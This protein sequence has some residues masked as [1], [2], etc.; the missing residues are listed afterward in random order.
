MNKHL[1]RADL[2]LLTAWLALLM[3][4]MVHR[5]LALPYTSD[6][7][8][9]GQLIAQIRAGLAPGRDLVT[10]PFH[11]QTLVLM[12]LLFWFGTMPGGMDLT[13]VRIGVVVAHITGALGCAILCTR[14]TGSKLAGRVAGMLYAGALGF[15]GEQIWWPSSGIF[16]LGVT[17]FIL[18]LVALDHDALWLSILMLILAALGLNGVVVGAL[19]LPIYYWL[20]RRRRPPIALLTAIVL[21][22]GL[23]LWQQSGQPP[24]ISLRGLG[25]GAWLVFTAPFRFLNAWT[26]FGPPGFRTLWQVAPIVWLP[27]LASVWRMNANYRRVL[28]AVWTPAILLALLIGFTRADYPDRFGPGS[29]YTTDRYYYFFLFPLVA[30]CALLLSTI[31]M[32]PLAGALLFVLIAAALVASRSRY[33]ANVPRDNFQA[34]GHALQQGRLLVETIRSRAAAQPLTLTDAPIPIDGARGNAL[35]LAFLIYSEY[36]Q[37]IPGVRLVR[38]SINAE[39]ASIENLLLNRWAASAGLPAS[40]ACV[41]DGRL[42]PIRASSRIDFQNASYEEALVSGFSWWEAPFRWMRARASLRL[43]A[44]PGDLVISAY[45]PVDQ[46]RRAIHMT[47]TIDGRPVGVFAITAPGVHDYRLQ[48]PAMTYGAPANIT[49]SS[50]LIW[51]ARDILPQS[52]DER[53]LSIAVSAIGLSDPHQPSEPAPCRENP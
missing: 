48:P 32:R 29:F 8:E 19:G 30:H 43:I 18:A 9:H 50:D 52:F 20:L 49:L 1:S 53:D 39:Q 44:A 31:Q 2:C 26:T 46:L 17:F 33:L 27:L 6:D 13:W 3:F 42:Q 41:E 14:W 35:T 10:I 16:C 15:I 45:A 24:Q 28:I 22:L 21:L 12:R 40:P 4:W 11:G 38:E 7:F 5:T 51:H 23:G 47:V 37:G 25:L 34:T 36:P